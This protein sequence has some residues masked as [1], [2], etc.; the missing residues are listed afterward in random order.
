M[1][2]CHGGNPRFCPLAEVREGEA[3][4]S[5]GASTGPGVRGAG[6]APDV[7]VVLTDGANTQGVSPQTPP[8]QAAQ[9]RVRVF[10]IGFGTTNP[11]PLVCSGSQF[12]GAFGGGFGLG[13]GRGFGGVD[14]H[15]PLVANYGTL[16]QIAATTGGTFYQARNATE[17]RKALSHLSGAFMIVHK[18][19][20]LAP[21][22]AA[23]GG[24]L[25]SAAVALSLWWRGT[26][27]RPAP[28]REPAPGG[29][30]SREEAEGAGLG[31][32]CRLEPA[33]RARTPVTRTRSCC[34]R[35]TATGIPVNVR[36]CASEPFC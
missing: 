31:L 35:K 25:A 1:M 11:A 18:Q 3:R 14:G 4:W 33:A 10:T 24:V 22:F 2:N 21:L 26:R 36:L 8:R 7:I 16:R 27:L 19:L 23:A 29:Q 13:F 15:N 17:L 9:R 20:D 30:T 12:G 32:Q 28:A 6:Y 5:Q 34:L